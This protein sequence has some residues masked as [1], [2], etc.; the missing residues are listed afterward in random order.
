VA[1]TSLAASTEAGGASAAGGAGIRDAPHVV[2]ATA[3]GMT[4]RPHA[5]QTVRLY[6]QPPQNRS[7]EKTGP[8]HLVQCA[9]GSVGEL[10]G[11]RVTSRKV[12]RWLGARKRL[13]GSRVPLATSSTGPYNCGA[14]NRAVRQ[15]GGWNS[16]S[17]RP[18]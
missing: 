2:Q 3:P 11:G 8:P 14:S 18:L 16:A 5:A 1:S 12:R 4:A 7:P 15:V 6:P 13:A 10:R 9:A 17:L